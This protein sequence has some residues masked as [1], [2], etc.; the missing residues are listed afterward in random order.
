MSE[1]TP[2]E[3]KNPNPTIEWLTNYVYWD[4]RRQIYTIDYQREKLGPKINAFEGLLLFLHRLVISKIEIWQYVLTGDKNMPF[5][6]EGFMKSLSC[7]QILRL[8]KCE[9]GIDLI[10]QGK[11]VHRLYKD[12]SY[13][14]R[15]RIRVGDLELG[16]VW[17]KF[18][19]FIDF[20]MW[21]GLIEE[22]NKGE[23]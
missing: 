6:A 9:Y 17:E 1:E 16:E 19:Y 2:D 12:L 7:E 4:E 8:L 22:I 3:G 15:K 5:T 21:H 23:C 20:D 11:Y 18:S 10:E 13:E 14:W